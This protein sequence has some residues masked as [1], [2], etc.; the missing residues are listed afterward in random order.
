MRTFTSVD[1]QLCADLS[2]ESLPLSTLFHSVLFHRRWVVVCLRSR[3]MDV[4]CFD[5]HSGW[6]HANVWMLEKWPNQLVQRSRTGSDGAVS[7]KKRGH[8][9]KQPTRIVPYWS[10]GVSMG[11]SGGS[12]PGHLETVSPNRNNLPLY[13]L[14]KLGDSCA[15]NSDKTHD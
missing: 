10:F 14:E 3:A 7:L 2:T 6:P 12:G 15:A 8:D 13:Q 4:K 11:K 9:Q 1:S 5:G